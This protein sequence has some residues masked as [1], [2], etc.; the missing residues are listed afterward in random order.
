MSNGANG[1]RERRVLATSRALRVEA[2]RLTAERGMS[3]FT[4]EQLCSEV[5]VSRRTFFNY[6][7]S[8]E[9][10]VIG[11]P[12][13]ADASDLEE[14]F[15]SSA[16]PRDEL[17]DEFAELMIARWERMDF[18]RDDID[19]LGQAFRREPQL[20]AHFLEVAAQ[21]ERHD[22]ALV[23]RREGFVP[24]DPRAATLVQLLGALIRPAMT[25]YFEQN[26]EDF[27][28]LFLRRL[29]VARELLTR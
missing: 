3:G 23:E 2:R 17:V 6:F 19:E 14:D 21:G 8:K 27:R 13:R 15:A 18:N 5:G 16:S 22:I 12:V 1:L 9:N 25:E 24:G 20:F 28:T 29:A 7:A 11:I 4:I 10:A 26:S